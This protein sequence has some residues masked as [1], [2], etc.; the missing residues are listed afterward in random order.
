MNPRD[1]KGQ[2][3]RIIALIFASED[4]LIGPVGLI[5]T[6]I[7]APEKHV[8]LQLTLFY[9]EHVVLIEEYFNG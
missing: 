5:R 9:I 8:G 6:H 1:E 4:C 3:C 2:V 7:R